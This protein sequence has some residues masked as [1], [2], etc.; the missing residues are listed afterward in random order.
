MICKGNPL[1]INELICIFFVDNRSQARFSRHSAYGNQ[2]KMNNVSSLHRRMNKRLNYIHQFCGSKVVENFIETYKLKHIFRNVYTLSGTGI[3]TCKA[4]K[5]SSTVV[6][7]FLL[8]IKNQS[9]AD[10]IKSMSGVD[11]HGRVQLT[12]AQKCD[13]DTESSFFVTRNPYTRLFSAYIDKIF[14]PKFWTLALSLSYYANNIV[15]S[16]N[17]RLKDFTA[18]ET[19]NGECFKDDI[20]FELFLKFVVTSNRMDAHWTP[21]SMLCDPCKQNYTA[22]VKQEHFKEETMFML[23]NFGVQPDIQAKI[24]PLLE[25]D[26]VEQSVQNLFDTVR[27][28]FQRVKK[29]HKC[30]TPLFVYLRI[31]QALQILGYIDSGE[32]FRG[33]IFVEGLEGAYDRLKGHKIEFLNSTQRRIQREE[34]LKLS[35]QSVSAATLK[36]VQEL[37]RLDFL[38]FGYDTTP[39]G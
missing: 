28:V 10:S 2:E 38:M 3:C 18:R 7:K 32:A 31:W 23:E 29:I 5:A 24:K 25:E 27:L 8:L 6:G 17:I 35:Y 1:G 4:P 14:V 19:A 16:E 22:I 13:P 34:Y 9:M 33:D 30:S 20:S 39:P 37:F 26:R 21:V 11:I 12:Y 15:Q 36:R